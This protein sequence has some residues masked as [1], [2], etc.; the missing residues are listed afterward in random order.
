MDFSGA[1]F[2]VDGDTFLVALDFPLSF[3]GGGGLLEEI[4]VQAST[5]PG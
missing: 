5:E 4:S 2:C 3:L 1:G